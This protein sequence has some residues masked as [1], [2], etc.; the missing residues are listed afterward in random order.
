MALPPVSKETL[1]PS[2]FTFGVAM[3]RSQ[4]ITK[5]FIDNKSSPTGPATTFKTNKRHVYDSARARFDEKLPLGLGGEVLIVNDKGEILEGTLTSVYFYRNGRFVTPPVVAGPND[6]KGQ[7][8]TTRRWALEKGLCVE[9]AVMKDS[10]SEGEKVWLS[11]GARGFWVG[12][13]VSSD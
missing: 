1:F 11:N 2:R 4:D 13:V 7:K 12:Q 8:G 9:E 5:V 10:V 6:W 3:E